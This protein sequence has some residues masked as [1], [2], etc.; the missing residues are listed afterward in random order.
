MLDFF[1]ST[2][3]KNRDVSE[4]LPYLQANKLACHSH[5]AAGRQQVSSGSETKDSSTVIVLARVSAFAQLLQTPIP[6]GRFKK[7]L[8]ITAQS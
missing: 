6:M 8:M 2:S 7:V 5:M 4:S 1:L 3:V